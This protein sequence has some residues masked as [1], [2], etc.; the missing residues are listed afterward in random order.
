VPDQAAEFSYGYHLVKRSL[1]ILAS[2]TLLSLQGCASLKQANKSSVSLSSF[3]GFSEL[4]DWYLTSRYSYPDSNW[5]YNDFGQKLH[6]RDT[7]EGPV[8]LLLHGEMSSVHEWEPWIETLKADYRIIALDLP[9]SGLTGPTHCVDDIE[10]SCPDNLSLAYLEHTLQYFIE[11]L[12]LRG[13]N[14]AGSGLGGFLAARYALANA[15]KVDKLLL[16][17]PSGMQQDTPSIMQ[18]YTDTSLIASLWQ[19]APLTTAL[20]REF[21]FRPDEHQAKIKRYI[22]LLQAP[23]AHKSNTVQ[24]GLVEDLMINGTTSDF[25]Q[26]K[27]DT[28][29][30]WG[31]MDPWSSPDNASKWEGLISDSILVRY[32]KLSHKLMEEAPDIT[33]ADALAFLQE[34]PLPSIEGLGTSGSFSLDEAASQFDAEGLFGAPPP[35]GDDEFGEMQDEF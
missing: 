19:P 30:L 15:N 1:I 31:D 29:V 4:P 14:I 13:L 12:Q 34:E 21:Y 26:L 16:L 33:V 2:V 28:L 9:G 23:G 5:I 8:L 17:S 25:S 27:V 22:D 3:L 35:E 11:D 18:V 20:V 7:G 6:Y 10:D 32:P 24:L